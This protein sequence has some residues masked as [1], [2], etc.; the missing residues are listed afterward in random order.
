M[1]SPNICLR[2][3]ERGIEVVRE[4][5]RGAREEEESRRGSKGEGEGGKE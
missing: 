4:R 3:T 1:S 5:G 2:G